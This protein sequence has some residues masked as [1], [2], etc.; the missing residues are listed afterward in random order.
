MRGWL[1]QLS[2][3]LSR[4]YVGSLSVGTWIFLIGLA[5]VAIGLLPRVAI[6]PIVMI[7]AG[8]GGVLTLALLLWGKTASYS[9][10]RRYPHMPEFPADVG[11][12]QG[13]DKVDVRVTGSFSVEGKERF[14]ANLEAIYHSFESREHAIMAH[15][16]ITRFALFAQSRKEYVG[17]WYRFFKPDVLVSLEA[18][19]L[20]HGARAK[21]ALRIT[22]RGE[23]RPE[24]I[25]L[26]F[27]S[28][29]DQ[30]RVI[31]DLA[32]DAAADIYG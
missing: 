31:A 25:Y 3:R 2:Y 29:D 32:H 12:L 13:L 20:A 11:P 6:S 23:K 18:G 22:C 4:H 14:F 15:V 9:M 10:F 26:A 1:L 28:E 27:E 8:V 30:I 7:V 21:P 5:I 19:E 16:P 17:M 24:Q